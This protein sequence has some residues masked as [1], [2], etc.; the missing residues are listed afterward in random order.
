MNP[1]K[2]QGPGLS[3]KYSGVIC[4]GKTKVP[5]AV[6]DKIQAHPCLNTPKQFQLSCLLGYWRPFTPCLALWLWPLYRCGKKKKKKKEAQWDWFSKESE[7]FDQAKVAIK[8]TQALSV[9]LQGQ[10]QELGVASF[11]E[12]S[13][14]GLW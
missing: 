11:P 1:Q 13:G 5:A 9:L 7:A 4:S 2:I 8:Q 12:R 6:I 3:V 10:P 14:W